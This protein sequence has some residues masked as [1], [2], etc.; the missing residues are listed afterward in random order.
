VRSLRRGG[1]VVVVIFLSWWYL[2]VAWGGIMEIERRREDTG[3]MDDHQA[4]GRR[5]FT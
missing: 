1:V 4:G 2:G 5:C 3:S